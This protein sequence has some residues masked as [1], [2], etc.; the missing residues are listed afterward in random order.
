MNENNVPNILASDIEKAGRSIFFWITAV[1]VF[2][3]PLLVSKQV[4]FPFIVPRSVFF[5]VTV[6]LLVINWVIL[7]FINPREYRI[8]WRN[9]IIIGAGFL[10]FVWII[11]GLFGA[12]W[13][14]SFW[15]TYQRMT[16]ILLLIHLFMWLVVSVSIIRKEKSWTKILSVFSLTGAI[17]SAYTIFGPHGFGIANSLDISRGGATIGN[18]SFL[19]TYV[20]FGIFVAILLIVKHFQNKKNLKTFHWVPLVVMVF[21]PAIINFNIILGKASI[22]EIFT[23]PFMVL[24]EARAVAGSLVLGVLVALGLY[25]VRQSSR[26]KK[27]LG[28]LLSG[29][30][31]LVSMVVMAM[32]FVPGNKIYQSFGEMTGWA[33]YVI[34]DEAILGFMERP[35][36]GWGPESFDLLHQRFFDS[37]LYIEGFGGELWFDRAHNIV[38][39]TLTTTGLVG[40]VAYIGLFASFFFVVFRLRKLEKMSNAESSVLGGLM[41]AYILQGMTVFDMTV[42]YVALFLVL[43]YVASKLP[44]KKEGALV[45]SRLRKNKKIWTV[46]HASVVLIM[47]VFMFSTSFRVLNSGWA[48]SRSLTASSAQ[49]RLE[50]Y[51][52]AFKVPISRTLFMRTV[53]NRMYD[54]LRKNP[55]YANSPATPIFKR[56]AEF[57][58]QGLIYEANKRP[59]NYRAFVTAARMAQ[60]RAF[61]GET[62][63]LKDAIEYSKKA[64]AIAPQNAMAYI[65]LSEV[66]TMTG[67]YEASRQT[68]ETMLATSPSSQFLQ[69][70]RN[71]TIS[72][73][74]DI[75]AG[76]V[77]EEKVE[78]SF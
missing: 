41:F 64:I 74:E 55:Q 4:F 48:I 47:V 9:P 10:L 53:A 61:L 77:P 2:L 56:E 22:S 52:T 36:L 63:K 62:G 66:Y 28:L 7:N 45:V 32:L 5:M 16:G 21:S 60:L 19:G 46:S 40:L 49:E 73:I 34:W 42:S 11:S 58:E 67:N 50:L 30:V 65:T 57:F 23:S 1:L 43:V 75:E 25:L 38:I 51:E 27:I 26:W 78:I 12:D 8:P 24:G 6:D 3:V 33:R 15:S 13:T 31:S 76:E 72:A 37:R 59:Y 17:V 39:D 54:A 20:L 35:F 44:R 71:S 29:G 14:L 68:V 18:T 69:N 70:V